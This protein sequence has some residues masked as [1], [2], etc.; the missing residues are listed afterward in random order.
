MVNRQASLDILL[1]AGCPTVFASSAAI[2][3]EPVTIPINES[4]PLDPV[5]HY[6]EQKAAVDEE[7][8]S[9][10][11]SSNPKVEY[12]VTINSDL[13]ESWYESMSSS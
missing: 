7:I 9:L 2:Y 8:R 13:L 10:D 4:H 1:E 12:V 11:K 3:G 5:G 6:G